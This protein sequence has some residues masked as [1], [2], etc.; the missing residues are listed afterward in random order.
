LQLGQEEAHGEAGDGVE[1][2]I[3]GGDAAA[4]IV[5]YAGVKEVEKRSTSF[6]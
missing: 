6:H 5:L 2:D 4:S 3:L 1:D